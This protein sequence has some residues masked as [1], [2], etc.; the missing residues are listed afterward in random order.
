MV[1]PLTTSKK[2]NKYYIKIGK[3]DDKE[4]SAII[5][6]IRLVDTKRLVNKV[7]VL[8]KKIFEEIR[9]AIRNLI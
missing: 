6:Q 9:K 8:D 3:V 7:G 4:A 2:N 5:S 1:V